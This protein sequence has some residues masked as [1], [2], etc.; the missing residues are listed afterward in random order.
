M[1]TKTFDKKPAKDMHRADII[2]ELKKRGWSMRQ[3]SFAHG[4]SQSTVRAAL[5]RPYPKCEKIIADAI[6]KSV[7]EIWPERVAKR[8]F[9]PKLKAKV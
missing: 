7:A 2:A 5:E 4:L 8:N 9:R 3:L 1:R 6:G